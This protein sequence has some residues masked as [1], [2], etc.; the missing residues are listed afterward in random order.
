MMQAVSWVIGTVATIWICFISV[1]LAFA[2]PYA[3]VVVPVRIFERFKKCRAG[4]SKN[5]KNNN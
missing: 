1:F 5:E 4:E 3:I 2:I